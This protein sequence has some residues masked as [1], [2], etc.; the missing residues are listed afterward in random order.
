MTALKCTVTR[1][2][3]TSD[4]FDSVSQRRNSPCTSLEHS[5][6]TYLMTTFLLLYRRNPNSGEGSSY[7]AIEFRISTIPPFPRPSSSTSSRDTYLRRNLQNLVSRCAGVFSAPRDQAHHPPGSAAAVS[8]ASLIFR[9][10]KPF[11][12]ISLR[13][14]SKEQDQL[15]VFRA[16]F[17]SSL[18]SLGSLSGVI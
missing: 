3:V 15:L 5:S 13:L 11:S 16:P 10:S 14:C 2:A 17:Q 4:Q 8:W 9:S 1:A 7:C 12:D 18:I 6:G